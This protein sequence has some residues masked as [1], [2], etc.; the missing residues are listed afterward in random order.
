MDVT[1]TPI[2]LASPTRGFHLTASEREKLVPGFDAD[3]LERLLARIIP[4]RR[5]E[6]LAYFQ[7]PQ[8]RSV[9]LGQLIQIKD[10]ELQPIL[11]EVWAPMWDRVG[12]TDEDIARN[13]YDFPGREIAQARRAAARQSHRND[14]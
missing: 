5:T 12:A 10:P 8:D 7:V 3:A 14:H 9:R 11:E 13:T 2:R 1:P 4:E 6:I